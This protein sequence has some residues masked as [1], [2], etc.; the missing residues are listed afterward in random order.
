[1]PDHDMK[2]IQDKLDGYLIAAREVIELMAKLETVTAS[3]NRLA[4]IVKQSI[5]L[6]VFE[7]DDPK[8]MASNYYNDAKDALEKR[9][10]NDPMSQNKKLWAVTYRSELAH[11]LE[12]C[13]LIQESEQRLAVALD[14][15]LH[16]VENPYCPPENVVAAQA[17]ARDAIAARPKGAQEFP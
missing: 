9:P 7:W 16:S 13:A 14:N 3:E 8:F 10:R 12:Q 1:M 2:S 6:R 11:F 15:L 5:E 4:R 17:R